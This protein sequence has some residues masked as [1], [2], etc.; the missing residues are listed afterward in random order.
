[1][2]LNNETVSIELKNGTIVHGTI[3]GSSPWLPLHV[4]PG[5]SLGHAYFCFFFFFWVL[6]ARRRGHAS[7]YVNVSNAKYNLGKKEKK[8]NK[9][10]SCRCGH[11][12]E[13]SF[14]DSEADI[15]REKPCHTWPS[16][17]SW[18][19]YPILHSPWQFES[20]HS[21]CWWYSS[22]EGQETHC[23]Y[24]PICLKPSFGG[25][26]DA[27]LFACAGLVPKLF[28]LWTLS[29]FLHSLRKSPQS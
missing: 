18:Q 8:T 29:T 1:M 16:Q 24:A 28:I 9:Q 5:R 27:M 11:Q 13:Y 26:E 7:C 17:Y 2:K 12:H 22:C 15:E 6:C 20:R 19:Q 10:M 14:E 4:F 21:S 3:T 25:E 23:W